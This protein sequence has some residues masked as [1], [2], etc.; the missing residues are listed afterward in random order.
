MP[1]TEP[2]LWISH[3]R[4]F[5]KSHAPVQVVRYEQ[6]IPPFVFHVSAWQRSHDHSTT[7]CQ[8]L[9]VSLRSTGHYPGYTSTMSQSDYRNAIPLRHFFG[10]LAASV[11]NASVLPSSAIDSSFAR[12]GL[13]PRH[14]RHALTISVHTDTGFG[15]MKPLAQCNKDYFGAQHLH[16]FALWLTNTFPEASHDSLPPHTPGSVTA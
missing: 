12:H 15:E 8:P 16:A 9:R 10:S 14:A 2:D 1:L 6:Y 7:Y 4:L 3:I 5:S 13:R 11:G